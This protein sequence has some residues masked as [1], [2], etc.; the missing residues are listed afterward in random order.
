MTLRTMI[1]FSFQQV[2]AQFRLAR[3]KDLAHKRLGRFGDVANRRVIDGDVPPGQH[4]E[5]FFV[6]Y[7]SS[8]SM[9]PDEATYCI[10]ALKKWSMKKDSAVLAWRD[11]A[12]DNSAIGDIAKA[13]EP[14]LCARSLSRARRN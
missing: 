1:Q 13:S 8:A 4:T 7:L 2:T 6:D 14:G 12:V 10:G 9:Q 3:D 5:S 11:I